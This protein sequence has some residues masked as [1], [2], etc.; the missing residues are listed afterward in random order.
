M[1]PEYC[2]FTATHDCSINRLL[3]FITKLPTN[4]QC[5]NVMFLSLNF[6][7]K[8]HSSFLVEYFVTAT[9]L[10]SLPETWHIFFKRSFRLLLLPQVK[11]TSLSSE[12]DEE[13]GMQKK[14]MVKNLVEFGRTGHNLS[15]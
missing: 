10:N 2:N 9:D 11:K 1:F 3:E 13:I 6:D 5:K 8:F 12:I 14:F 4:Q 7:L 15:Q